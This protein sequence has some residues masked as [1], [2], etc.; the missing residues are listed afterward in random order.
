[1][2]EK[3]LKWDQVAV[4]FQMNE[5]AQSSCLHPCLICPFSP[6]LSYALGITS[7]LGTAVCIDCVFWLCIWLV[8]MPSTLNQV[9]LVHRAVIPLT[10]SQ[11]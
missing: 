4:K 11:V 1:M 2:V 8:N 3:R 9:V 10:G 5:S 6:M 7:V